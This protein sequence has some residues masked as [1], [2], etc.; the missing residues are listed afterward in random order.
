MLDAH[1]RHKLIYNGFVTVLKLIVCYLIF[2][3]WCCKP[4]VWSTRQHKRYLWLFSGMTYEFRVKYI[5]VKFVIKSQNYY[6]LASK[7]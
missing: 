3:A 1:Y 2:R 6:F 4:Q 5:I 7:W